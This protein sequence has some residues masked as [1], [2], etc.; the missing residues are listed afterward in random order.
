VGTIIVA[1]AVSVS[2]HKVPAAAVRLPGAVHPAAVVTDAVS[3]GVHKI[4]AAAIRLAGTVRP[5][6]VIAQ[7]VSVRIY[8]IARLAAAA[9]PEP[10]PVSGALTPARPGGKGPGEAQGQ[11]DPCDEYA[12]HPFFHIQFLRIFG[13]AAL[14]ASLT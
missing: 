10:V 7:A 12:L 3:V 13:I 6:A 2:I 1:D 9:V 8:I 11:N 4:P 5:A 14:A